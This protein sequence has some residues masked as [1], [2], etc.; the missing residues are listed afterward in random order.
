MKT[1]KPFRFSFKRE[2]IWMLVFALGPAILGILV[3]LLVIFVVK[4]RL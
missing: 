1:A 2:P 4:H 3:A